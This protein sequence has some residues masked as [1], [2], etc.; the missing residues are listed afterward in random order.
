[1]SGRTKLVNRVRGY[2]RTRR[3]TVKAGSAPSFV[4]RTRKALQDS[5]QGLPEG[6][7]RILQTIEFL[8]V[9]I[10]DADK[11][12]AAISTADPVCR[13]LRTMPGVGPVTSIRFQAAIDTPQRF[14]NGH[15]MQ[16]YL[17]LTPGER[18]S[19]DRKRITGITKAG[20][21]QLRWV[22]VQAAWSLWRTQPHDPLVL[23]AQR[24]AGRR[25]KPIAILALARKMSGVLRAMWLSGTPYSP[26]H[27][28]PGSQTVVP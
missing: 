11:E 3:M 12:L 24:V 18:S 10:S 22:L 19:S 13:L 14:P 8:C 2:L 17:G 4:K 9:Q 26:L 7:E 15:R 6:V 20:S 5:E 1:M 16:S 25:G 21:S 27:L 23:W 28:R